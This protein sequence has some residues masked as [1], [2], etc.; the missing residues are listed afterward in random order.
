MAPFMV[1]DRSIAMAERNIVVLRGS[2]ADPGIG[3]VIVG[4]V[5]HRPEFVG[6][7]IARVDPQGVDLHVVTPVC[8]EA[9]GPLAA[10]IGA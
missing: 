2:L 8:S 10:R 3:T 1:N 6:R 9:A 4:W 5:M 7:R